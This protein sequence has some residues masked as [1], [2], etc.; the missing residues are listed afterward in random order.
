MR[1]D[2]LP[3]SVLKTRFIP[4]GWD[5][6][7]FV[8][9]FAFF[10]YVA[11]A[12]LGLRGSLA[13]LEATPI[14]LAP[15]ALVGYAARTALRMLIA[16]LASLLFTFTYATLAAKSRRAEVVLVPL[17]DILQSLPILGFSIT[18]LFFLSLTPGR[19]A[20]A[21]MAAVFLIFTSQAWNMAFS[22]YH[23]LRSI[24]HE[25][26]EAARS[27]RLS[28]WMRFWRLEVPFAMPPLIWN[29]MMSMSGGWFFVVAA[30]AINV[31]NTKVTL[32]GVGSY[33]A[34]AIEQRN[35]GAIGWAIAAMFIVILVYDQLLFRPLIASA[36]WFRLEQEAGLTPSQSWALT[37]M[38]RSHFLGL[39][40]RL[41]L[42]ILNIG[43]K[44][45]SV[46]I[47]PPVARGNDHTGRRLG[48]FA[49]YGVIA[50]IGIIALL[51]A[52]RFVFAEVSPAEVAHVM[53]LGFL[54]F[55]RVGVLIAIASL[56]WVPIGIYVG[57]RPRLASVVQPIAQFLAAFPVNLIYPIVV[58]SIVLGKLN[59]NIWLSPLMILGTQWYILFNVIV[60]A[61]AIPPDMRYAGQNFHVSG[62]LWWKRIA[63]PAIFPFY[64]TGAITASGGSW[65]ASVVSEV[66]EWGKQHLTA[67]G[68]G[69]YISRATDAGDFRRTVVG[70]VVMAL[71]V[72][73]L[74]RLFWKP[75]F[76]RAERKFRMS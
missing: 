29:M 8:L 44:S 33:V 21:E 40:A 55:L 31:G 71:F 22:F 74:N 61:S 34:L 16:M 48:D 32:P 11:E 7:A 54:T 23:S 72:V 19:V 25:L 39:V 58:S 5:V 68:L 43:A 10:I 36:D 75:L 41:F 59:P 9:V 12:A 52:V 47:R 57:L 26:N 28:P 50:L 17:L 24:P 14:S 76:A 27:F 38:R 73:V 20:G 64:V 67:A 37:M 46:G 2:R 60:G 65:N 49:W 13:R 45:R 56:I 1:L 15:S 35:L 6:L 3:I 51:K 18:I 70:I 63:L 4:G 69:S 62:W 66:A 30:E 42:G 53:L